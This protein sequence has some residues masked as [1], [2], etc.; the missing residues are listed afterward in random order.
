MRQPGIVVGDGHRQ[1]AG[2]VGEPDRALLVGP[3]VPVHV[4][5]ELADAGRRR[6]D[7]RVET[8][9]AELGGHDAADLLD[10]VRVRLEFEGAFTDPW[11]GLVGL[12]DHGCDSLRGGAGPRGSRPRPSAA[13]MGTPERI[14]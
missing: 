12:H 14:A 2:V 11:I 7:E 13:P 8:P 4:G 3:G 6:V 5:E 10:P 9:V 1:A